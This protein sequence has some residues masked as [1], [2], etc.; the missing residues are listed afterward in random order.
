[1]A[2]E[3]V[4]QRRVRNQDLGTET[5]W[6]VPG[7]FLTPLPTICCKKTGE[8]EARVLPL[9]VEPSLSQPELREFEPQEGAQRYNGNKRSKM[10]VLLWKLHGNV[11]DS[12]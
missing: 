10:C 6:A 9:L 11:N 1:M 2:N 5:A 8:F 3:S 12:F 4:S 7:V